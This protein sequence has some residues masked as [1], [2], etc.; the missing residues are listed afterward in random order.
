MRI[1][2]VQKEKVQFLFSAKTLTHHSLKEFDVNKLKMKNEYISL[3]SKCSQMRYRSQ[4]S[5]GSHCSL[6]KKNKIF[7]KITR[8]VSVFLSLLCG[9]DTSPPTRHPPQS[10]TKVSVLEG[11]RAKASPFV[12]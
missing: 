9:K 12:L 4:A 10:K 6:H 3:S 5:V 2:L 7:I 11:A 8:S 1:F